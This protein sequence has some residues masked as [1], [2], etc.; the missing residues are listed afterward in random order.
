V[1]PVPM[2]RGARMRRGFNQAESIARALA[3]RWRLPM[4]PEA[5]AKVRAT[6]PQS[7][8]GREER[9]RN[10]AGAFRAR[11]PGLNGARVILVDDLVTTGATARACAYALRGAGARAVR[12]VCAGYRD[13]A[14][15]GRGPSAGASAG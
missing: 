12:V 14:G 9:L 5:I 10:L 2:D 1:V 15:T 3:A 8:L 4:A 7:S 11:S 13:D 6:R